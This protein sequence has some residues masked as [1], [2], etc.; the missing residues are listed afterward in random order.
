MKTYD[1]VRNPLLIRDRRKSRWGDPRRALTSD[2]RCIVERFN[3]AISWIHSRFFNWF[4][5]ARGR[6][7]IDH[8]TMVY[9]L[10]KG[11]WFSELYS[12]QSRCFWC[13]HVIKMSST[14]TDSLILPSF[15]TFRYAQESA[16]LRKKKQVHEECCPAGD[17]I[18]EVLRAS[19]TRSAEFQNRDTRHC[20]AIF[21]V[22]GTSP[23]SFS[24]QKS[25]WTFGF[26]LAWESAKTLI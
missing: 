7:T 4:G 17:W 12:N 18:H 14:W 11:K 6:G 15:T 1:A 25:W 20:E 21:V 8:H 10:T 13:G 5:I 3:C 19:H 16:W 24:R 26:H 9:C 2:L 22:L 23:A